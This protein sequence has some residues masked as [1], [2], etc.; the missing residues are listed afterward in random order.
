[1]YNCCS[2]SLSTGLN[3]TCPQESLYLLYDSDVGL[4]TEMALETISSSYV[5]D[6]E[7]LSRADNSQRGIDCVADSLHLVERVEKQQKVFFQF[8]KVNWASEASPTLGC[9]IEITR[10]I[11][12]YVGMYIDLSTKNTY[13]KMRGRNYVAKT[14]ACSKLA[15]GS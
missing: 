8:K 4:L 3:L 14:H 6:C 9:S 2:Y 11:Y 13:A 5:R 15:L 10:D 1:M 12:P 7:L